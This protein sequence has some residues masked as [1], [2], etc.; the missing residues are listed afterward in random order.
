MMFPKDSSFILWHTQPTSDHPEGFM[1]LYFLSLLLFSPF[2]SQRCTRE[3]RPQCLH[4]R[5]ALV[6]SVGWNTCPTDCRGTF[7]PAWAVQTRISLWCGG[8]GL[9]TSIFLRHLRSHLP[10]LTHACIST[11]ERLHRSVPLT[12]PLGSTQAGAPVPCGSQ[13]A[14]SCCWFSWCS[15]SSSHPTCSIHR[16]QPEE[17]GI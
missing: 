14:A 2:P 13:P 9:Q 7:G 15:A 11:D 6:W 8:Q 3:Q 1:L 4:P 12:A 5:K 16:D 17:A 10:C